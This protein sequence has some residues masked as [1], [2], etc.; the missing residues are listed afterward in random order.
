MSDHKKYLD[1][2]GRLLFIGFGSIGQGALPLVLRH[3]GIPRERITIVTADERGKAAADEYGIK[4]IVER[5]TRENFRR[6]LDP[7]IGRGD[8][9]MNVSVDVSSVA[10]IKLC[11]EKG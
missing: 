2:P 5:L 3:I 7:L 11:W 4:F 10:L 1:F 9:V 8:F 6:V